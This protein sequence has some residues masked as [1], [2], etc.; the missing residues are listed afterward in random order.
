MSRRPEELEGEGAGRSH[1]VCF[2]CRKCSRPAGD[3]GEA[4]PGREFACPDCQRPMSRLGWYFQAPPRR[5][6]RHWLKI[7]LLHAFGE[8][9]EESWVSRGRR[10]AIDT[11]RAALD[12][13]IRE[14]GISED[15]VRGRLEELR[16]SHGPTADEPEASESK[17]G[18]R[19]ARSTRGTARAIRTRPRRASR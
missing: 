4:N 6:A 5:A 18:R 10:G 11:L 16:R 3:E 7:E 8:R 9:F 17:G 1:Y 15:E 2:A 14:K 13:L 19:H 12:Y